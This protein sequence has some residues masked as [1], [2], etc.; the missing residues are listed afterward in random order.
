MARFINNNFYWNYR[1]SADFDDALGYIVQY[2]YKIPKIN[3]RV[4]ARYTS[5]DYE[6]SQNLDLAGNKRS[7]VDGDSIGLTVQYDLNL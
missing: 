6:F 2:D 1:E 4:G 5:I 7:D 3:L